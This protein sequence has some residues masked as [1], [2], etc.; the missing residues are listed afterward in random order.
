MSL[1]FRQDVH[2][3]EAV[4]YFRN[5]MHPGCFN[6]TDSEQTDLSSTA[7]VVY[8]RIRIAWGPLVDSD[9]SMREDRKSPA[10]FYWCFECY[11]RL[12]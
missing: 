9:L 12:F 11:W 10:A 5:Q 6:L 1:N 3:L 8:C 7:D 4:G 2:L